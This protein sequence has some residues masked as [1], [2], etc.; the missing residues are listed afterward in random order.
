[1]RSNSGVVLSVF[2]RFIIG[3][4]H[5]LRVLVGPGN[6]TARPYPAESVEDGELTKAEKAHSIGLM[7]VNHAGEVSAQALYLSQAMFSSKDQLHTVFMDAA[8]EEKD[9][10]FWCQKRL[11]E[12]GGRTSRLD[13]FWFLGAFVIGSGVARLGDELSL[14]FVEESE[15]QVVVHLEGHLDKIP[16]NDA[17]SRS[18][19]EE[20]RKDEAKHE[21]HASVLGAKRL[22]HLFRELMKFQ[23]RCM[24]FLAYKV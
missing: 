21:E 7:R 24:T 19:I 17:R 18:I 12:L 3:I 10:L 8:S 9:H 6:T 16:P 5:G 2:D 4:D 1:M 15:A 13:G 14:G 23:A 22:P 11:K 20:M